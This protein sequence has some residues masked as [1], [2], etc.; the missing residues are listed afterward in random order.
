M[1]VV[2]G[3]W[4]THNPPVG[5]LAL[6]RSLVSDRKGTQPTR[7]GAFG[8]FWGLSGPLEGGSLEFARVYMRVFGGLEKGL[9]L[10]LSTYRS[11]DSDPIQKPRQRVSEYVNRNT[12]ADIW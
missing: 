11:S 2:G 9:G 12:A 3:V 10:V 5:V 6:K 7:L 8:A 4:G 1:R